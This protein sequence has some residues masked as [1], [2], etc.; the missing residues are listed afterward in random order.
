MLFMEANSRRGGRA[1][2][3]IA[4]DASFGPSAVRAVITSGGTGQ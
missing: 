2:E 3:A 4:P 1:G